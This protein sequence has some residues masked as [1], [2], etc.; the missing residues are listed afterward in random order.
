MSEKEKR[1]LLWHGRWL[2]C[3]FLLWTMLET[4]ATNSMQYRNAASWPHKQRRRRSSHHSTTKL[5]P[6]RLESWERTDEDELGLGYGQWL[7]GSSFYFT[8]KVR[9]R[10]DSSDYVSCESTVSVSAVPSIVPSISAIS[11]DAFTAKVECLSRENETSKGNVVT[12]LDQNSP[13]EVKE[14]NGCVIS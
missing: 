3:F 5:K 6:M 10:N 8:D 11:I 1:T 9:G 12:L 4:A 13:T 7:R 2:Q 14:Q